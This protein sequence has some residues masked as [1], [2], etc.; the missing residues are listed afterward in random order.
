MKLSRAALNRLKKSDLVELVLQLQEN[1]AETKKSLYE[2]TGEKDRKISTFVH[3]TIQ[4]EKIGRKTKLTFKLKPNDYLE[5]WEEKITPNGYGISGTLH[6]VAGLELSNFDNY[7]E[8]LKIGFNRN[9]VDKIL[10]EEY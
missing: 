4:E 10:N 3:G 7:E 1:T 2:M 5:I 8:Y 6:M 9:L